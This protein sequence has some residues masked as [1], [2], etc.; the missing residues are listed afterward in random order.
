[1]MT[2]RDENIDADSRISA[3]LDAEAITMAQISREENDERLRDLPRPSQPVS[4]LGPCKDYTD[5]LRDHI[6]ER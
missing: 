2:R 3:A 4:Y 6:Y 1:M 5:F